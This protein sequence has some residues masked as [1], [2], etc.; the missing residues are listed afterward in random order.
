MNDGLL[1]RPEQAGLPCFE[2]SVHWLRC[3]IGVSFGSA[4]PSP[5]YPVRCLRGRE[6]C[7]VL[8]NQ[9]G[10]SFISPDDISRKIDEW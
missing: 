9:L 3:I 5:P 1:D 7:G 8:Q 10:F 6:K 2:I 4:F